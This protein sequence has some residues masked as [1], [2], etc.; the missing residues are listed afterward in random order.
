LLVRSVNW[1]GDAVMSLPAIER[2]RTAL[3]GTEIGILTPAKLASLWKFAPPLHAAPIIEATGSPWTVSRRLRGLGFDAALLFPNSHRVALEAFLARIPTRVGRARP[4]RNWLLTQAIPTAAGS[5]RMRKR[6]RTEIERLLQAPSAEGA[7]GPGA[8]HQMHDYLDLAAAFGAARD[9]LAPRLTVDPA[10]Q[11]QFRDRFLGPRG[12]AGA[13][14]LFG[15]C[16]GAEYGSAK[17]WPVER[18][19]ATAQEL[20]RRTGCCWLIFGTAADRAIGDRIAAL[21][22]ADANRLAA[23]ATANAGGQPAVVNLAGR[24]TLVE[25]CAGL[26]CCDVVLSNDSGPMHLAAALGARVLAPFGSTSPAWT[27]PGA[28]GS[29]RHR[30]LSAPP[31][32]A[33][34]FLRECPVDFRCMTGITVEM[35]TRAGLELAGE[36]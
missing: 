3:P 24:T 17:R 12:T 13:R 26:S 16:P 8:R 9:P 2:L 18:F 23:A 21:Q 4:W 5:T 32:C 11:A 33:P 10:V 6:S 25:L 35:M 29:D 36:S 1:L 28:P 19:A 27:G 30:A 31:P 7:A 20:A 22:R 34:C 14:R 15:L